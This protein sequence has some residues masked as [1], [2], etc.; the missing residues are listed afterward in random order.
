[1]GLALSATDGTACY[2]PLAHEMGPNLARDQ[3]LG[4]LA[5][6]LADPT[7]PKVGMNLKRD[8]H[9][10]SGF[11]APLAGLAFD[12]GIGSFLC[13]P[14][15][16]HD[17]DSLA[18]DLLGV[19]LPVLDPETTPRRPR[20]VMRTSAAALAVPH[21]EAVMAERAAVLFPLAEALRAQIESRD[22]ASLYERLEHR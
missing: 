5:L 15:R 20:P 9:L 8:S 3:V 21:V 17:L 6:A 18:R 22:Q 4:W 14:G 11:G 1:M 10:L 7:V 19:T 16:G 12:L 13:D 2:L